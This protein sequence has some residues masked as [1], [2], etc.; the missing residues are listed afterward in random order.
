MFCARLLFNLHSGHVMGTEQALQVDGYSGPAQSYK[1]KIYNA[2]GVELPGALNDLVQEELGDVGYY[3]GDPRLF[4]Y[5]S[6]E[7]GAFIER[8]GCFYKLT[9]IAIP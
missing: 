8:T 5:P 9:E 7:P 2:T 1:Y 4:H 3:R 6:G